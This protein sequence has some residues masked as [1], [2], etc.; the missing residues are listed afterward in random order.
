MAFLLLLGMQA[1]ALELGM[2]T[3]YNTT[4]E[5]SGQGITLGKKFSD[6]GLAY[7]FFRSVNGQGISQRKSTFTGNYKFYEVN[8]YAFGIKTGLA[9]IE[10]QNS[11][12]NG[13][14]TV[15]GVGVSRRLTD[16]TQIAFEYVRQYTNHDRMSTYNSNIL[17]AGVKVNF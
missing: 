7:G 14:T 4:T 15:T 13:W 9:Y 2:V 16:S 3:T 6:F 1:H 12:N 11:N 17:Q 5:T 8:G 10:K